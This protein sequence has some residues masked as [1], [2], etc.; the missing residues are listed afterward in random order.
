MTEA[1]TGEPAAGYLTELPYLDLYF[2][3]LAPAFLAYAALCHGFPPP[4]LDRFAYCELGCGNGQ[5][6]AV[7]AASNPEARFFGCDINPDHVRTA[8]ALA[9]AGALRNLAIQERDFAAMAADESLPPFDYVALH[10]VWSWVAPEVRGSILEFLR[11][12]LKPGGL[13]YISYNCMPGWSQGAPLRRLLFELAQTQ[14]G[15]APDRARAALAFLKEMRAADTIFFGMSPAAVK[16]FE[17]LLGKP[18]NYLVHEY[19][20]ADWE[21]PYV[22]DMIRELAGAGFAY[23]GAAVPADNHPFLILPAKARALLKPG[24]APELR[25][26][27]ADFVLMRQF[28]RDVFCKGRPTLDGPKIAAAFGEM[29]VGRLRAPADIAYSGKGAGGEFTFHTPSAETVA[30][31]LA[32]GPW[33]VADIARHPEAASFGENHI[34]Q[35]LHTFIAARQMA[36]FPPSRPPARTTGRLRFAAAFNSAIAGGLHANTG[37]TTFAAPV[38]GMG[39]PCDWAQAAL[40]AALV[41]GHADPIE[42][43]V[44]LVARHGIALVAKER[45]VTEPA[46]MRDVL[47]AK[48]TVVQSSLVPLFLELGVLEGGRG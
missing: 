30:S 34:H 23:A 31:L 7:L 19:L 38:A 22:V 45:R 21:A 5:T 11:R 48:W 6:L 37:R 39:M 16:V 24:L 32:F 35:A 14:T 40:L 44:D 41:E 18:V 4:P 20:S 15:G 2:P 3:E 28:R 33:R 8:R 1:N 42:R 10:G 12:R 17:T 46:E 47:R 36:L 27:V 43:V 29:T 26:L 13:C 9:D 25:Q